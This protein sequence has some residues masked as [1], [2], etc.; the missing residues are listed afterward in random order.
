W[1][2]SRTAVPD[3]SRQSGGASSPPR[4]RPPAVARTIPRA[5][6]PAIASPSRARS[7][8]SAPAG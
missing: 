8:R 3:R 1:E 2:R 4:P 6:R 7:A 5:P